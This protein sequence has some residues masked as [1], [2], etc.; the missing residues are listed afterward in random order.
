MLEFVLGPGAGNRKMDSRAYLLDYSTRGSCIT[1][2]R[3]FRKKKRKKYKAL[4]YTH[5]KKEGGKKKPCR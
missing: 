5:K 3:V 2:C 4:R 1:R